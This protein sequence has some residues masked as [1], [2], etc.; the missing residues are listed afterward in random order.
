MNIKSL[1]IKPLLFISLLLTSCASMSL[2]NDNLIKNNQV[3]TTSSTTVTMAD[4]A[5]FLETK[6]EHYPL[7]DEFVER[8]QQKDGGYIDNALKAGLVV[9]KYKH[10]PNQ[11]WHFFESWLYPSIEDGTLSWDESA[12]SRVYSKLLC[13]ELLLWIYEACEVSP[14]KVKEAKD[15]AELA[16]ING[17]N[18][19]T[20]AKNM[21]GI[22]A[23]EDLEKTIINFMNSNVEPYK[24]SVETNEEFEISSLESEY[25][26]GSKVTFEVNVISKN[27]LIEEVRVNNE[28]LSSSDGKTYSFTMPS[29]DAT[30]YVTLKDI[31]KAE[32]VTL[33][34][35]K[36][37]INVGDKNKVISASVLPSNTTDT[38]I[39][40]IVEGEDNIS[41]TPTNN[42]V[43]VNALKEG[44]AKIR[45]SYNENVYE[46]CEVII[47]ERIV[48][49]NEVFSSYDIK[50][51]LG[52]GKSA[53]AISSEEDLLN[54]FE[55][56]GVG[57]DII[58]SVSQI[59]YMYGGAHGGSGENRWYTGDILKFGTTSI[60]G[61]LTINFANNMVNRVK[62]TGYVYDTSCKVRIGDSSSLDF[63]DGNDGLTTLTTLSTMSKI[64]KEVVENNQVSSIVIDF[65]ST[66]SLRIATTNKK[67][68]F[69][70][71]IEFMYVESETN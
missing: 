71:S 14:S 7:S 37:E 45:V 56:S 69:I 17:T 36:L 42:E 5:S 8:Y 9:D 48:S 61:G 26:A 21:R 67:P 39:W 27:K 25:K 28:V 55:F 18:L 2:G 58:T 57:E 22:V 38:P 63:T 3:E 34:I 43:K 4:I 60:N 46:E 62:I 66:S 32:S 64:S 6:K 23:W 35:N 51:D 15:I 12:K 44:T 41:I 33:S 10:E 53:K 24:L 68:L 54:A 59:E 31:V 1:F 19:S 16:K 47:N 40:T 70:T 30:I 52:T 65:E 20:M 13:P 29:C 11:K 49:S 50:Y